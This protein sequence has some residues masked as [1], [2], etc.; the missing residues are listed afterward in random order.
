VTTPRRGRPPKLSEEDWTAAA[1]EALADGGLA[2]VAVEP[3]AIRLG[4]TKG[5]FYGYFRN[6]D[7][8]VEAALRRWEQEQTEQIAVLLEQLPDPVVR[9]R[10]LV[11]GAMRDTRGAGIALAL[12]VAAEDPLIVE[13][14]RRVTRRR[15]DILTECFQALGQPPERARQHALAG[16]SAYLGGAALRHVLPDT[17]AD[18]EYIDALLSALSA[19]T[20]TGA[21]SGNAPA[22]P[23]AG[24]RAAES[25]R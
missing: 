25:A 19:A 1:L 14:V 7:A 5:S 22:H 12:L 4:A 8:L 2:A 6:R 11:Q 9:L 21:G 24:A 3:L 15:L 10:T 23:P 16:Y 13:V 20:P 18:E 17:A